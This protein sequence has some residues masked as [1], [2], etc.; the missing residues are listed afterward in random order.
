MAMWSFTEASS[1]PSAR[2]KI[3]ARPANGML[4]KYSVLWLIR[5]DCAPPKLTSVAGNT[6]S[7]PMSVPILQ[8]IQSTVHILYVC[9]CLCVCVHVY[10]HVR[11]SV[12]VHVSV[13]VCVARY[14]TPYILMYLQICD[15]SAETFLQDTAAVSVL[16]VLNTIGATPEMLSCRNSNTST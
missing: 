12:H 7:V 5:A 14:E 13:H 2:E 9:V 16:S 4:S 1:I 10:V 6:S 11:V 15:T 8:T 3:S